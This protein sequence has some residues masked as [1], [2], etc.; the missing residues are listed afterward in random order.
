MTSPPP[1]TE[2]QLAD[3]VYSIQNYTDA[4]EVAAH[5]WPF[6]APVPPPTIIQ[7]ALG[8]ME[9]TT[10]GWQTVD[11]LAD[12]VVRFATAL[13]EKLRAAE[14]KYGYDNGWIRDDWQA[15]CQRHLNEHLAKGDPR[16]VAA[17]CAFLWHHGWSTV[18]PLT[19]EDVRRVAA[20]SDSSPLRG[21]GST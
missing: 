11:P 3:Y 17:Y 9:Y 19:P 5:L 14:K 16:D 7:T 20:L 6:V 8:P 13:L 21:G 1:S 4:K 2:E 18:G 12:L 10:S 15:E